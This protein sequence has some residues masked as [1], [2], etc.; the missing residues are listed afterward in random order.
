MPGLFKHES[1]SGREPAFRSGERNM[2]RQLVRRRVLAP[3]TSLN[4]CS[5]PALLVRKA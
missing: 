1:G 5:T 3:S 2:H 4:P